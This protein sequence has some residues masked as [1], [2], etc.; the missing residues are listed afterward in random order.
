MA[1][2]QFEINLT[3][4]DIDKAKEGLAISD[5]LERAL[6]ELEAAGLSELMDLPAKRDE[7]EKRKK[8]FRGII[9]VYGSKLN[10]QTK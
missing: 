1:E 10:R 8:A 9:S 2:R 6:N 5:D 7:L 4:T 3:Q